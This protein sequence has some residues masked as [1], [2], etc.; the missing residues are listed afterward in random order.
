MGSVPV[1]EWDLCL[2]WNGTYAC[3][4]MGSMPVMEWDLCLY[5]NV[6]SILTHTSFLVQPSWRQSLRTTKRCKSGCFQKV[7]R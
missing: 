3:V 2:C 7:Y 6:H 1:L 5:W 4:G